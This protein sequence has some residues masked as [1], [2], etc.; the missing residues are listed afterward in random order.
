MSGS[1]R[2]QRVRNRRD[3]QVQADVVAAVPSYADAVSQGSAFVPGQPAALI[4]VAPPLPVV[5]PYT[6]QPRG[7]VKY[8]RPV[9]GRKAN[10]LTL[11]RQMARTRVG[12]K[13]SRTVRAVTRRPYA[14]LRG[15]GDYRSTW[16]AVKRGVGGVGRAIKRLTPDGTFMRLGTAFG[17]AAGGNPYSAI[18]GGAAGNLLAKLVGFG[19]YNVVANSLCTTSRKMDMGMPVPYFGNI[20]NGTV[21]QHREYVRDILG[22]GSVNFSS[23]SMA[24]NPGLNTTFPWLAA[25]A[26]QYE[27]Y[28]LRGCVFEYKSLCS[29]NTVG[30][31]SALG[32][33]IMATDYDSNDL[34]FGS[35]AEMEQSQYCTSTKPSSDCLHPIECA[36]NRTSIPIS[37][38]RTFIPPTGD[39]RLYDLG[40]LTVAQA[41]I[42][43]ATAPAGSLLGELWVTYEIVLYKPQIT[44]GPQFAMDHFALGSAW[45]ATAAN[46]FGSSDAVA[47]ARVASAGSNLGTNFAAANILSFPR[48]TIAGNYMVI[49]V[50]E[51][52]STTLTTAP[53]ITLGTG[54]SAL[55]ILAG[56]TSDLHMESAGAVSARQWLQATF[57]V[58]ANLVVTGSLTVAG[59]TLPGTPTV[60]DVFVIR[61]P[62]LLV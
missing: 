26:A 29:D 30:A 46:A 14:R 13:R 32:S 57:T 35:K 48:T 28:E 58:G 37:Y 16:E 60:G 7:S 31:A 33:I 45:G 21:I 51:G 61:M 9:R 25:I 55:N 8:P 17:G 4:P 20:A 2:S 22:T 12:V 59:G 38:I 1:R 56:S 43:A 50:W 36:P 41:G 49:M 15:R 19:D 42:P 10:S 18:A 34:S 3:R 24:I 47:I 11:R 27:Q 5:H 44:T 39:I 62:D 52:A 53:S 54:L 40:R 6:L 23:Q